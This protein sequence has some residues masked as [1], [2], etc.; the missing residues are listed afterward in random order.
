MFSNCCKQIKYQ[1]ASTVIVWGH[2]VCN[3]IIKV[4]NIAQKDYTCSEMGHTNILLVV[5]L[6]LLD[7]ELQC[8]IISH[9]TITAT[10]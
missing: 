7:L 9:T 2:S 3:S 8:Y 6:Y 10:Y 5:K 1:M 4:S